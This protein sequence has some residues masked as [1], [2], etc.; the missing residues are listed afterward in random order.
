MSLE[1]R[2]DEF[3]DLAVA[4]KSD[5]Q[6]GE[7]RTPP[8][9]TRAAPITGTLYLK[10]LGV[11][12]LLELGYL[13]AISSGDYPSSPPRSMSTSAVS[14]N[15]ARNF[16][17]LPTPTHRD[18]ER[19]REEREREREKEED[20]LTSSGSYGG[21]GTWYRRGSR[22]GKS[23]ATALQKQHSLEHIDDAS[24]EH[25]ATYSTCM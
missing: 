12:G 23:K 25:S 6:N 2:L 11:E 4:V 21:G 19:Q 7:V 10:L 15:Q 8:S 17:T 16:M 3:P 24:S 18:R 22:H 13:R 5:N 20:A 9:H 1:N 14:K